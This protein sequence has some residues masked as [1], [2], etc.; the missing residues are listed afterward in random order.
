MFNMPPFLSIFLYKIYKPKPNNTNFHNLN[1]THIYKRCNKCFLS[2]GSLKGHLYVHNAKCDDSALHLIDR[3]HLCNTEAK[4]C[5]EKSKTIAQ[6]T[7]FLKK[8][9]N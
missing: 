7:L 9:T 1:V 3:R 4:N 6:G 2:I 5:K 8:Q